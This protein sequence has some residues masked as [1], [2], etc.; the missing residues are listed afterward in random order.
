MEGKLAI[1]F[2]TKFLTFTA[3]INKDFRDNEFASSKSLTVSRGQQSF[4]KNPV[5]FENGYFPICR[6]FCNNSVIMCL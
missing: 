5:E 3:T 6:E 4:L 2:N 1:L